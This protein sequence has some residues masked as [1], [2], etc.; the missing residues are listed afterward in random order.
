MI[1]LS[2]N[3]NVDMCSSIGL[4]LP[5]R[6]SIAWISFS[7]FL[8][9][10][11]GRSFSSHKI[12]ITMG[13]FVYFCCFTYMCTRKLAYEKRTIVRNLHRGH[14]WAWSCQF[15]CSDKDIDNVR[16]LNLDWLYDRVSLIL[17]PFRSIFIY[18]PGLIT[19]A[20]GWLVWPLLLRVNEKPF[21][22]W[23]KSSAVLPNFCV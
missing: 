13:S 23:L 12:M 21:L 4:I 16:P 22:S 14:T 11:Q 10:V 2:D 18:C 7:F 17:Q 9:C 5:W 6:K 19:G 15:T 1:N 8:I 3:N 20:W